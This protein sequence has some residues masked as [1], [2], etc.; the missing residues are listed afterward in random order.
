MS[1]I[2]K[3]VYGQ[4]EYALAPSMTMPTLLAA[5]ASE[6]SAFKCETLDVVAA[7]ADVSAV[8]SQ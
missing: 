4:V 1:K 6:P 3:T 7:S 5:T 2:G 8:K